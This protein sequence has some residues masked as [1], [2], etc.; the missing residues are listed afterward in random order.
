MIGCIRLIVAGIGLFFAMAFL[1]LSISV[2]PLA[3]GEQ[4]GDYWFWAVLALVSLAGAAI[5]LSGED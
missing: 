2:S 5:A 4:G 1:Y 3:G